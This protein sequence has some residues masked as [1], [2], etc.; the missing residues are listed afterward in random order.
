MNAWTGLAAGLAVEELETELLLEAIFQRF[1]YDFRAYDRA[2]L[3]A[4]LNQ[5]TREL[6]AATL[7][8]LQERALHGADAAS[9]LLRAL[10]PAPA[11][12][13]DCV[14]HAARLRSVLAPS[15]RGWPVPRV[16]LAECTGVGEAWTL[17]I[18]LA[19]E[20]VL[21]KLDIHATL[22]NEELAGGMQDACLPL[23]ELE[24]AR[25]RH[26]DSGGRGDLGA[27]FEIEEGPEGQCA[28]LRADLRRRITWSQYSLVT[29]ASFNE[30]QAILCCHALGDFGPV[31]RQ[32]V[33]RLFHDS[34]ARFGVLC[35][36]SQLSVADAHAGTYQA[37]E[38]DRPWYKRVG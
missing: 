34:L 14:G 26:L 20:G 10:S 5:A 28:R 12:L 3:R 23:A 38:G 1:G 30:F 16:W 35:L 13:F 29:D 18:V 4:K 36:D 22:A 31:L 17:A 9:S 11:P 37:I 25:Q 15:L 2:A 33:L 21:G 6:G 32:R 19:E 7:S 27:F 24:A 8:G